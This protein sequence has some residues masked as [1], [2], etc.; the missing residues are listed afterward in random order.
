MVLFVIVLVLSLAYWGMK[1]QG[2]IGQKR[3]S[4][5]V[6]TRTD[7]VVGMILYSLGT[8]AVI[9]GA[10]AVGLGVHLKW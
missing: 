8:A 3:E 2:R 9:W 4:G 1:A 10:L 6:V 5:S 7:V